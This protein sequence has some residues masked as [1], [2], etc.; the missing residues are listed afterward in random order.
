[1][2]SRIWNVIMSYF[3]GGTKSLQKPVRKNFGTPPHV[4]GQ[5]L[6][7]SGKCHQNTLR[8]KKRMKCA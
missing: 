5:Y 8:R 3:F 4:Y 6:L 7:R 1:M 2:I